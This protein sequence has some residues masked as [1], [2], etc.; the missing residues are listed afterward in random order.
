MAAFS[1]KTVHQII[2]TPSPKWAS[3]ERQQFFV[4]FVGLSRHC[5]DIIDHYRTIDHLSSLQYKAQKENI[6]SKI[7]DIAT[8]EAFTQSLLDYE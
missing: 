2:I 5:A 3:T 8:C 7:I 6:D 1:A 4:L